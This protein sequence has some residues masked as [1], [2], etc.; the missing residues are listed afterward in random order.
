MLSS[1]NNTANTLHLGL[2][3]ATSCH[4]GPKSQ[5]A[6]QIPKPWWYQLQQLC[7]CPLCSKDTEMESKELFW[8]T[9]SLPSLTV[10]QLFP[11][12][13][14]FLIKVPFLP[15]T[16]SYAKSLLWACAL[17]HYRILPDISESQISWDKTLS[18]L[19]KESRALFPHILMGG[20]LALFGK[21]P[22][23]RRWRSL[24]LS[25]ISRKRHTHFSP[26]HSF[27]FLFLLHV[28]HLLTLFI[29]SRSVPSTKMCLC[30]FLALL[31]AS[32]VVLGIQCV[33]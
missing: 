21:F 17:S 15:H 19:Q 10:F 9:D 28:Y 13:P 27:V 4:L 3:R 23:S 30:L 29:C 5:C 8:E 7:L 32:R 20:A 33:Q 24:L 18:L 25:F 12:M 6:S 14:C 26:F 22:L 16:S 1:R 11:D 31:L 2:H